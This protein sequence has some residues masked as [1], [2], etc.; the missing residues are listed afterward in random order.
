MAERIEHRGRRWSGWRIAG[1][2]LAAL[3]LLLPLVAMRFTDEVDWDGTDFIVM[4]AL[5]GSIG[6]AIEFMVRQSASTAYRVGAVLAL[7]TAFLTIWVNLAVGMIGSEDNPHNL[8]F[9]GVLVIALIGAIVAR[10]EPAGMAHAAV[11]AAIAQAAVAAAGLSTDL[12]GA[13][14]SMVFAGLWLLAAALFRAA[15]H[16]A[17]ARVCSVSRAASPTG[18]RSPRR[19]PPNSGPTNGTGIAITA[20]TAAAIA[21]RLATGS[22]NMDS[23]SW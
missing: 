17:P 15:R 21:V 4:G 6:L 13:V 2:G 19:P 23:A 7:L 12:R 20:P 16:V 10:F 22:S 3:L 18:N 5:I 14:F 9:G 11:A 1:W 8:L